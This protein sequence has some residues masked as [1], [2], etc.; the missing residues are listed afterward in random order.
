MG[1]TFYCDYIDFYVQQRQSDHDFLPIIEELISSPH[2][3][4]RIRSDKS[5]NRFQLFWKNWKMKNR[6]SVGREDFI[7]I[8]D[9]HPS[10]KNRSVQ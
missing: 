3:I 1:R 8:N 10:F 9:V 6:Q 2:Y 4:F 5:R 7:L